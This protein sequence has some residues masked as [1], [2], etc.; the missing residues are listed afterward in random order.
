MATQVMTTWNEDRDWSLVDHEVVRITPE[1]AS[2]MLARNL[3]NRPFRLWRALEFMEII[4]QGRFMHTGEGV[5]F[6][7][8]GYLADAQHRLSGIR[9]SGVTV[10]M[11]VRYGVPLTAAHTI[12]IGIRRSTADILAMSGVSDQSTIASSLRLVYLY[13]TD[14]APRLRFRDH[15]LLLETYSRHAEVHD[16]V[17]LARRTYREIKQ[18]TPSVGVAAGY[19]TGEVPDLD[20]SDWFAGLLGV[21]P[22][23]TRDPRT[24]LER[25]L[26]GAKDRGR[27]LNGLEMA[28]GYGAAYRA[29]QAEQHLDIDQRVGIANVRWVRSAALPVFG[30]VPLLRAREEA[31]NATAEAE[32]ET[33]PIAGAG[34]DDAGEV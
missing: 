15:E 4:E 10:E 21:A 12:N 5:Q 25:W 33:I 7:T 29:Y 6:Y 24:A 28:A 3:S 20:E 17:Q 30:R 23:Y 22:R 1:I 8:N 9:R 11:D 2:A 19:L 26:T 18:L 31:L 14:S 27:R 13:L 34:K 32:A 16:Y